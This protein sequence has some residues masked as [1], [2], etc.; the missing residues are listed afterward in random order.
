MAEILREEGVTHVAGLTAGGQWQIESALL[1][2]GIKRIHVRHEATATFFADAMGRLTSRPGVSEVGPATGLSYSHAGVIQ[3]YAAQSPMVHLVGESGTW[4][5]DMFMG[6][7]VARSEWMF[8]NQCKWVRR[9]TNPNI[10][11]W[12]IKQAFRRA[13]TPPHGPIVIAHPYEF[14]DYP[15][16]TQPRMAQLLCYTPGYWA[17]KPVRTMADPQVVE[18]AMKW[19]MEAERPAIIVGEGI[20]LQFAQDELREFVA[21]TGIPTHSR[22]NTR[23]CPSEYDPLNCY[24]RARG[25][26]MREA[27]RAVVMGLRIAFL[28]NFGYP[29]FW[30]PATQYIQV[31]TCRENVNTA[32]ATLFEIIGDLKLVLRQMIDCVKSLGI[33]KPPEKWNGWRQK[34]V[35]WKEKYWNRAIERTERF[36]GVVPLHP[37]LFGRE[38]AECVKDEYNDEYISVMDAFSGATFLSD[39][40]RLK[41]APQ[42]VD[43]SETIG[44][45]HGPGMALAAAVAYDWKLPIQVAMGDGAIGAGGMDIETCARWDVPA[46][47]IHFNNFQFVSGGWKWWSKAMAPS[48]DWIKD[49]WHNL[50]NIRY[51]RMFR[52]FGCHTEL[53]RRDGETRSAVKRAF[54][55]VKTKS[56]P[57]FIEAWVDPDCMQEIWPTMMVQLSCGQTPWQDIPEEG[58]KLALAW[59]DMVTPF[60]LPCEAPTWKK[61]LDRPI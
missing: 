28:E 19:L 16:H 1:R 40:Q 10:Y 21:L 31:Q 14:W 39:W 11:L 60:A 50:P 41:W 58:R 35:E 15:K 45:G 51:D 61:A 55:F 54:D 9:V 26:V 52:E 3:A 13:V 34:V 22:R 56:K 48:G 23:G 4:D 32:L 33:T 30:G 2:H 5:D 44:F 42:Q 53:V 17:P 49:G 20:T 7:G 38:V 12:Y 6:Q 37:E 36:R 47:F 43:A 57:A 59:K 27:D 25:A 8:V 46:V 29:P 18:E 24:G